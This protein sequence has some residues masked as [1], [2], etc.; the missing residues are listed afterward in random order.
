MIGIITPQTYSRWVEEL[1]TARQP[2]RVGRPGIVPNLDDLVARLAVENA[3]VGT[4]TRRHPAGAPCQQPLGGLQ[5]DYCRHAARSHES[6]CRNTPRSRPGRGKSV[7]LLPASSA[8]MIAQLEPS[9]S[10]KSRT[11]ADNGGAAGTIAPLRSAA[12]PSAGYLESAAYGVM[13]GSRWG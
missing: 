7:W 8:A 6:S 13:Y 12:Q 5:R 9:V 3:K 4:T 2:K 11:L 10:E 1:R